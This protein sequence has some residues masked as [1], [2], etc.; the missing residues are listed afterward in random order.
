MKVVVYHSYYGCATGCCGHRVELDDGQYNFVFGHPYG[1][2]Q[3]E[4]AKHLVS[5]TF[6]EQ[7]VADLDWENCIILDDEE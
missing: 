5:T 2:D 3:M 4:F 7:H 6:G 1:D